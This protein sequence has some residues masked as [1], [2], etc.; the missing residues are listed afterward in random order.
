MLKKQANKQ[1][2]TSLIGTIIKCKETKRGKINRGS[3]NY[4]VIEIITG[5]LM[6]KNVEENELNDRQF[7]QKN[8]WNLLVKTTNS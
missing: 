1:T 2:V 3:P 7:H 6:I 4:R 5:T 8:P